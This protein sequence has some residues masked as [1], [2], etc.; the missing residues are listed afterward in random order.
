MCC[1][2][3]YIRPDVVACGCIM[4]WAWRCVVFMPALVF[5][6]LYKV[7]C[8]CALRYVLC[9][10]SSVFVTC[11]V[12]YYDISRK[13]SCRVRRLV[14]VYLLERWMGDR[15]W[16]QYIP[17]TTTWS[18]VRHFGVSHELYRGAA[19]DCTMYLV[20]HIVILNRVEGAVS[21]SCWNVLCV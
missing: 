18:V 7:I 1:I 13:V 16:I 20:N 10:T 8:A 6:I 21:C 2:T 17:R 12:L 5:L 9:Y 3:Y 15:G 4:R 11:T 14:V 19:C